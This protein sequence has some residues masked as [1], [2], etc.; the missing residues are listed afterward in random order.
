VALKLIRTYIDAGRVKDARTGIADLTSRMGGGADDSQD[1]RLYL[2]SALAANLA[3]ESAHAE[4]FALKAETLANAVGLTNVKLDAVS[5]RCT[6]VAELA[7]TGW[8]T[9]ARRPTSS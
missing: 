3:G 7:S 8:K 2:E 6:A 5:A 4:E 9:S 1:P